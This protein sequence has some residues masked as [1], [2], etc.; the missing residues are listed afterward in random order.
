MKSYFDFMPSRERCSLRLEEQDSG[1]HRRTLYADKQAQ[2]DFLR[3]HTG[4]CAPYNARISADQCMALRKRTTGDACGDCTG[5]QCAVRNAE[6]KLQRMA[7]ELHVSK[8]YLRM[9]G[10]AA[11]RGG[12]MASK[13]SAAVLRYMTEHGMTWDEIR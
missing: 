5:V 1:V 12:L 4:F 10:E 9:M 2:D 6:D 11:R 7:V 13:K 3:A 8:H